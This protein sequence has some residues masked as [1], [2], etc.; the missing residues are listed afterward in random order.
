MCKT[1]EMANSA[2]KIILADFPTDLKS[3]CPE[4]LN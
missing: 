1:Q 3:F 4:L 2:V